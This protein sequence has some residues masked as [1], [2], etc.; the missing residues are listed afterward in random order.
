MGGGGTSVGC[1]W[2]GRKKVW[3]RK[4]N[5][6]EEE[7]KEEEKEGAFSMQSTLRDTRAGDGTWMLRQR[8]RRGRQNDWGRK[9]DKVREEGRD[10][11]NVEEVINVGEARELI[12]PLIFQ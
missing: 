9:S 2:V 4:K 7:E 8:E 10:E 5:T 12:N 6:E 1:E 11:E 3:R